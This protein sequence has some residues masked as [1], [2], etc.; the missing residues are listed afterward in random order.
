MKSLTSFII[1]IIIAIIVCYFSFQQKPQVVTKVKWKTK[2]ITIPAKI[3]TFYEKIV[4]KKYVP[5]EKIVRDTVKVVK[6]D[7][8]FI[9][10]T[11]RVVDTRF[12]F[13]PKEFIMFTNCYAPTKV[14]SIKFH[15]KMRQSFIDSLSKISNN[16]NNTLRDALFFAGGAFFTGAIVYMVK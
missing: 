3:D 11:V 5:I 9:S 4:R 15:Y 6:I 8:V 2:T 7:T 13:R 14:D 16:R 12:S 1:G 10:D